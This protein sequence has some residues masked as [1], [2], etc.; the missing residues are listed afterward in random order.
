MSYTLNVV[1]FLFFAALAGVFMFGVTDALQGGSPWHVGAIAAGGMLG[2][3]WACVES[4]HAISKAKDVAKSDERMSDADYRDMAEKDSSE[5]TQSKLD[6]WYDDE[7]E[8][9][10][11]IADEP[12]T[13]SEPPKLPYTY[14]APWNSLVGTDYRKGFLSMMYSHYKTNI[15][16]TSEDEL[17][18]VK[19]LLD[20]HDMHIEWRRT[21][22]KQS[23]S[24][25]NPNCDSCQSI[26]KMLALGV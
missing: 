13:V 17:E 18:E 7:V 15:M 24:C 22:K 1:K 3:I 19:S 2:C 6:E 26:Q 4:M 9:E 8:W 12:L 10:D 5:E 20:E 23:G 25:A 21:I 11:S 14:I 16:Y